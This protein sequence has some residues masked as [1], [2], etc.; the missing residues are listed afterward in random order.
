MTNEMT[1]VDIVLFLCLDGPHARSYLVYIPQ[2]ICFAS[3]SSQK[4]K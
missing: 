2:L 1:Y 4:Y 3:A